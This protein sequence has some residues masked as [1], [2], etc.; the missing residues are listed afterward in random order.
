MEKID[1]PAKGRRVRWGVTPYES[2][3][4]GNNTTVS[5]KDFFHH[6]I[7]R[8]SIINLWQVVKIRLISIRVLNNKSPNPQKADEKTRKAK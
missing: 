8:T 3:D 5:Y 6:S 4:K 2:R 1:S 7:Q